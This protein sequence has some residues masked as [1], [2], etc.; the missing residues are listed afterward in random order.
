MER[1][2][3]LAERLPK[4][5]IHRN[6]PGE[7]IHELLSAADRAWDHCAGWAPHGPRVRWRMAQALLRDAGLPVAP[8]RR[9]LRDNHLT[10]GWEFVAP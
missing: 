6:V 9:R 2:S 4:A 1:P 5:L 10:V 8:A 3:Q 7:G